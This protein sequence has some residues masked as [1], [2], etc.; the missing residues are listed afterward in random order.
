WIGGVKITPNNKY[1]GFLLGLVLN[2]NQIIS[3]RQVNT[4]EELLKGESDYNFSRGLSFGKTNA[5][6]TEYTWVFSRH[7]AEF[8]NVTYGNSN[9]PAMVHVS[10]EPGPDDEESFFDPHPEMKYLHFGFEIDPI[11]AALLNGNEV[12]ENSYAADW[13]FLIAKIGFGA[14][15]YEL[16]DVQYSRVYQNPNDRYGLKNDWGISPSFTG[17]YE[18]GVHTTVRS[19]LFH[20]VGTLGYYYQAAPMSF[21]ASLY[22]FCETRTGYYAWADGSPHYG[23]MGRLAV[24]F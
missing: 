15:Y 19:P 18:L 17:T 3:V 22:K 16:S 9:Y 13:L 23:I 1:G 8:W 24:T 11:R 6:A 2:D 5:T 12:S 7:G 21:L 20:M 10:D 14:Y 4:N